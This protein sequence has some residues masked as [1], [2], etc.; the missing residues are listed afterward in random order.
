MGYSKA[1]NQAIT[2]AKGEYVLLLNSDIEVQGDAIG[3]LPGFVQPKE[4]VFAGGKLF[5]EDGSAQPSCGP[6][7]P[8]PVV[9]PCFLPAETTGV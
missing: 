4:K 2:K 3:T 1:N 6:F 9:A 8:Y 5:N 7:F